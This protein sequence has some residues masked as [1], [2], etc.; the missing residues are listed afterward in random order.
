MCPLVSLGRQFVASLDPHIFYWYKASFNSWCNAE[1]SFWKLPTDAWVRGIVTD[2]DSTLL[3][4]MNLPQALLFEVVVVIVMVPIIAVMYAILVNVIWQIELCIP[5]TEFLETLET[6]SNMFDI[7]THAYIG[8]ASS[9]LEDMDRKAPDT[10]PRRREA[11]DFMDAATY[12]WSRKMKYLTYF[13]KTTAGAMRYFAWQVTMT[14]VCFRLAC[15]WFGLGGYVRDLFS[16]VGFQTKIATHQMWFQDAAGRML[17]SE[18]HL[19][20]TASSLPTIARAFLSV[21]PDSIM[22]S[23]CMCGQLLAVAWFL[24]ATAMF[25]FAYVIVNQRREFQDRWKAGGRDHALN[26]F[27][28]GCEEEEKV[29]APT[30]R[31]GKRL[32]VFWQAS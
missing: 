6:V 5:Q 2:T 13:Y 12:W 18:H 15:I 1:D 22:R 19:W 32:S 26:F 31:S 9:V 14:V 30:T 29:K 20:G 24:T 23:A 11:T 8:S 17:I 27:M 4:L 10:H 3:V 16:I 7:T 21:L 25:A 28:E